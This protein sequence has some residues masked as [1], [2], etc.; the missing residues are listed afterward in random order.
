MRLRPAS[1][2]ALNWSAIALLWV[3]SGVAAAADWTYGVRPGDD[4][5]RLAAKYCGSTSFAMR[6]ARHNGLSS[7]KALQAGTRLNIPVDWLVRQPADVTVLSISGTVRLDNGQPL[8]TGDRVQM[9]QSVVT[10]D[11]FAVVQFADGSQL[12]IGQHSE[13]LFNI[14]TAFGDT[15]MVDTHLR[16]YR[17]RGAA[18][19]IKR[20]TPSKFRIWTPTGIAAV[21]GTDFRVGTTGAGSAA[22]SRIETVSGAVD[23]EQPAETLDLPAGFGAIASQ[24]GSS[25]EQLL[26]APTVENTSRVLWQPDQSVRWQPVAEAGRYQTK[27]YRVEPGGLRPLR[28][29]SQTGTSYKLANLA[30][31][32]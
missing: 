9:G 24:T 22:K 5:W 4:L 18:R 30:A 20:E 10:D 14:L 29:G 11:G 3:V 25:K 17:G 19:V 15:G 31:G 1:R 32:E 27:I 21:R 28:S 6:I 2:R 16:F 7:P 26:V 23:F 8:A 13:V 12:E